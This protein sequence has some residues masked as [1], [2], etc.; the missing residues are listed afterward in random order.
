MSDRTAES[1]LASEEKRVLE[2]LFEDGPT[3]ELSGAM[4]Q[5]NSAQNGRY[6]YH[7]HEELTKGLGGKYFS[8]HSGFIALGVLFTFAS[9]LALAITARGRDT[10]GAIFFASWI[11]FCGF[12]IGIMMELSLKP[13]W[14]AALRTGTGWNKL[15]PATAAIA[16]FLGVILLLLKALTSGIS[17]SY[18][19][20]LVLTMLVNFGWGPRLKRKSSLGRQAADEIAGFFLFLQKTDQ[21]QMNRLNPEL[22]VPQDLARYLPYAIALEVT[23]TWGDH[24]SQTFLATT[25]FAED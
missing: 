1:P 8:R 3:I 7:I 6:I 15:L 21:D 13:Q 14:K 2:L 23:E 19:L 4:D 20:M 22:N 16:V 17:L 5:R 12:I 24:L 18:S 9:A 11:L 25:V 10:T